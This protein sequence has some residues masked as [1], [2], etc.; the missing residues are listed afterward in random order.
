MSHLNA[1][2]IYLHE[3]LIFTYLQVFYNFMIFTVIYSISKRRF[4]IVV[5]MQFSFTITND[6]CLK[7]L[8]FNLAVYYWKL[9]QFVFRVLN[10]LTL[11][12]PH[13]LN[14]GFCLMK[15]EQ[16]FCFS[17]CYQ[18]VG[19]EQLTLNIFNAYI[20]LLFKFTKTLNYICLP[21]C[22]HFN[23]M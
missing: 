18:T 10:M 8:K 14:D 13:K 20:L 11:F 17:R 23:D 5:T 9:F 4:C 6:P 22:K 12:L 1:M 21:D 3:Y 7:S 16:K 2:D 15:Q 19:H